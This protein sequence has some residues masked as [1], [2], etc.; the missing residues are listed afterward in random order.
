MRR[1]SFTDPAAPA[2]SYFGI[3]G[4]R[5]PADG[6]PSKKQEFHSGV[7]FSLTTWNLK[8]QSRLVRGTAL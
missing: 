1:P 7:H 3:G 6:R 8:K 4:R 5:S 2:K